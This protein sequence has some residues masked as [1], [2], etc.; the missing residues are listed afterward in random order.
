LTT[1]TCCTKEIMKTPYDMLYGISMYPFCDEKCAH[2]WL[3][4]K[5]VPKSRPESTIDL[6]GELGRAIRKQGREKRL[7][8][9][10]S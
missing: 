8:K 3:L 4:S 5:L 2:L 6:S 9:K 1:C 10:R 7:N